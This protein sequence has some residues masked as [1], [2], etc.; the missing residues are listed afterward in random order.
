MMGV[1]SLRRGRSGK[2]FSLVESGAQLKPACPTEDQVPFPSLFFFFFSD[3]EV[4]TSRPVGAPILDS[5]GNG[6]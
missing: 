5:L 3:P 6:L 4:D 1:N 2:Q